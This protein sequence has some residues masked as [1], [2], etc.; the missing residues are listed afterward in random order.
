M[1]QAKVLQNKTRYPKTMMFCRLASSLS[2]NRLPPTIRQLLSTPNLSQSEVSVHGWVKSVRHQKRLA[3]AVITDG[4]SQKG[5][6]A[7]FTDPLQAK[8]YVCLLGFINHNSNVIIQSNEWI[9]R[10]PG[11]SIN[12][13]PWPKAE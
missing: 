10:T 4:S 7:V 13:E 1:R 9:Q 5:I 3:F 8:G 2:P 11:G 12:G 6:Q